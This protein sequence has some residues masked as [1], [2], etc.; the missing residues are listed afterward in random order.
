MTE[1]EKLKY[2]QMAA[3]DRKRFA[4]EKSTFVK[5][6]KTESTQATKGKNEGKVIK[7]TVGKPRQKKDKE[8]S[9]KPKVKK[10]VKLSNDD[11]ETQEPMSAE[12]EN[13]DMNTEAGGPDTSVLEEDLLEEDH[14]AEGGLAGGGLGEGGLAG[15]P[16]RR[17][18]TPL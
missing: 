5:S 15:G 1:G 3:E 14:H 17:R 10:P 8:N 18:R 9:K 13:F 16:P 7:K 4:Q 2:Q 11:E 6:H 12:V